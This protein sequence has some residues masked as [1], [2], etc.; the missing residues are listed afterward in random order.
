VLEQVAASAD[1][2]MG[3]GGMGTSGSTPTRDGDLL[4]GSSSALLGGT[5][6]NVFYPEYLLAGRPLDDPTTF[7]GKAGQRI[8]LRILNAGGDT[9]FRFAIGGHRLTVTHADGWPVEPVETDSVL[10][11]MGERVDALVTLGDGAFP[12]VALAEGKGARAGAIVRS[13]EAAATPSLLAFDP[14]PGALLG[15]ALRAADSVLLPEAD[16]DRELGISLTGGMMGAGWGID[17]HAF[18]PA[19]P[20]AGALGVRAGERV[21]LT[22]RNR[23]MMWHPFHLHGHTF[24]LADGG[25]RK[26][27]A[28][29]LPMGSLTVEFD[30]DN[31]GL[32]AAHC[33]NVYHAESGMMTVLGYRT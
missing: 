23:T 4:V 11:G 22:V 17:G 12:M 5:A 8:R 33:H 6:G 3:M 2:G 18:D 31:P 15:T 29:V 27:T 32:W 14:D 9:A 26:D 21:R 30:A 1:D 10:L 19:D 24:Q 7:R 20:L 28:V 16:V 13:S 25:A